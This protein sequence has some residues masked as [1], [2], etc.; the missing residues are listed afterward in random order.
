MKNL[1]LTLLLLFLAA[2]ITVAQEKKD[3]LKLGFWSPH[4]D[5]YESLNGNVKEIH[6]QAYH[7]IEKD[8]KLKKGKP[9]T[10]SEAKGVMLQQPWSYYF[11]ESGELIKMSTVTD[12]GN[13]WI[14]VVHHDED[15]LE[16]I[17][18]LKEDTL[19][20]SWNYTYP[21]KKRIIIEGKN[22]QKGE[23]IN[24]MVHELDKKGNLLQTKSYNPEGKQIYHWE[25]KRNTDGKLN[26]REQFKEDGTLHWSRDNYTYNEK[27]LFETV[28]FKVFAGEPDDRTTAKVEYEYDEKG[29]WV[30]RKWPWIIIE[31]NIVYYD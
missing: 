8:G 20:S 1:E 18:W 25:Y 2:L 21:A 11:D 12:S 4:T 30:E 19:M 10:F 22:I 6:Y 16:C 27:G 17:Y 29:N 31:R 28:H 7:V 5:N 9:R 23:K 26:A 24:K 14:G 3:K 13:K 15:K